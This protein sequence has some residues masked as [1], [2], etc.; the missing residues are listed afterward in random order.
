MSHKQRVLDFIKHDRTLT[1][2]VNL[3]NSL[4]NKSLS[5]QASLTR[6]RATEANIKHI[7]Y[8]LC[9][10]VGLE[11]RQ[12][13]ALWNNKV[14]AK[15]EEEKEEPKLV[16]VTGTTG[17][18]SIAARLLSFAPKTAEWKDIQ[19][20]AADVSETTE[21]NANGRKK[22][23]LLEFIQAERENV[24]VEE[25]KTVPVEV[26]KSIKLREQFPFLKEKDCPV[27]L[28]ALVNDLITTYDNY[29]AGRAQ[30]FDSMTQEEE[31]ILAR[32]IVDNFI[33]NKQIFEELEHYKNTGQVL[34]LHPAFEQEKVKAELDKMTGEELNKKHNALRKNISTNNKKAEA[35]EDPEAK[36]GYQAAVESYTWELEY[37]KTLLK[38]K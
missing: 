22:A 6:M 19:A 37:V 3:Y 30:L 2:A 12:M 10:A 14:L 27:I 9:K 1:G 15:V 25:S 35:T 16:I 11:E 33:E 29:K 36:A 17:A 8:Q 24:L 13:L 32:G 4:P 23:D 5:F 31:A 18:S 26:K 7:A 38:K 28:K 21:R 20:L 34:A